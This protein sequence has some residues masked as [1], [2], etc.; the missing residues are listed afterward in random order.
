MNSFE[1][2]SPQPRRTPIEN[3]T[4]RISR[5]RLTN[6]PLPVKKRKLYHPRP[7]RSPRS[8]AARR[9][10]LAAGRPQRRNFL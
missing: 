7:P 5:L 10:R 8:A 2:I 6:S 4:S 3:I 1:K 9:I